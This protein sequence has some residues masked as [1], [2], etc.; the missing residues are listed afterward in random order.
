MT[1]ISKRRVCYFYDSDVGA[2]Q[3]APGHPMK[4]HRVK[5]THSLVVNYGLDKK[6]EVYTPTRSTFR[7]IT[8][9]HEDH[10]ID[11]LRRV[12]PEN[13]E[14]FEKHKEMYGIWEDTPAFEGVYEFCSISAGGSVC[15]AKKLNNGESDIGI[16][17]AGG[18]HH[19]K[20]GGASG[21]CYV[22][23][24]VLGIL[25]L[26]KTYNRVLYVDID[27][28]HGDGVE[29]AFYTTD[30]VMTCSFHKY[31]DEY[32]P[33]TGDIHD[34]GVGKGKYYSVNF[35]LRDGIDD[36]TFKSIFRPVITYIMN[37]YR[38]GAVVLQCGTDSLAGD[39]L[40]TANLSERGHG[41]CAKFLRTFNVPMM[42]L[43]GG[44]YTPKNV[45]RTWCYETSVAIGIDI[46]VT[47][48]YNDYFEYFGP[49]YLIHVRPTNAENKNTREYLDKTTVHILENLR[50]VCHAPS[51]QMQEV[52]VD[53]FSDEEDELEDDLDD[54]QSRIYHD[55]HVA[56]DNELDPSDDESRGQP[57]NKRRRRNRRNHRNSPNPESKPERTTRHSSTN[58][59]S[60]EDFGFKDE[61]RDKETVVPF[62]AFSSKNE[63]KDAKSEK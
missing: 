39:R 35:P 7:E 41:A 51:V 55:T 26:L 25:E 33:G 29:E 42:L 6:M 23:D 59:H 37:W 44:G 17:W 54:R 62:T 60:K 18:L 56:Y 27:N 4:P 38:P 43:G 22:N 28:H 52:P 31:G 10:Y 63:S 45:S 46:P 61:R 58:G 5:M 14:S 40:G 1:S 48:P 24:I 57:S 8:K 12:T 30:R 15:A 32:F 21:F 49:E 16:N 50:N 9:F 20:R 19:A 11:F 34:I 2:Y 47:L 53:H 13:V 3:L 36:E